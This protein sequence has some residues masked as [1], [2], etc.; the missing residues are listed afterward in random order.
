MIKYKV[1]LS[2]VTKPTITAVEC[3]RESPGCVWIKGVARAKQGIRDNYHDTWE[4]AHKS[5]IQFLEHR[6]KKGEAD[7]EVAQG[8]LDAAK[9]M[10]ERK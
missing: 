7:L 4:E 1:N 6:V 5:L 3:E 9:L 10:R 8:R 2:F